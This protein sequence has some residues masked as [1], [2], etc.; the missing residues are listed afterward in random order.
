MNFSHAFYNCLVNPVM[1]ALL[2]S[3]IHAVV[4]RNIAILHY[5]GRRSGRSF[6]TPLSYV[7]E[8]DTV[9]LLSSQNTGWWKN[10]RDGASAVEV[11]IGGE[12]HAGTAVL[13]EGDTESLQDGVR[14]F[15]TALPR[16]AIVYG[17]KLDK[18]KR[19]VESSIAA[20][21]PRLVVVEISLE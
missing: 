9:L 15:L 17:V 10:F 6:D 8:G 14:R 20:T 5:Q 3:P 18:S 12:R 16:D 7:R 13:H 1:R 2:R 21:A 11:E 4:S 19:P